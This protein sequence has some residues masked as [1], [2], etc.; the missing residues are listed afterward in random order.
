MPCQ[1]CK[2]GNGAE[3]TTGHGKTAEQGTPDKILTF[4]AGPSGEIISNPVGQLNRRLRIHRW[5][6]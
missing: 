1:I 4:S 6:K 5:S 3:H 2:N